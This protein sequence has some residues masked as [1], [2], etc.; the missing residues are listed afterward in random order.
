[1]FFA[2]AWSLQPY[3]TSDVNLK[4]EALLVETGHRSY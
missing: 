4:L 1:M 2:T 3:I